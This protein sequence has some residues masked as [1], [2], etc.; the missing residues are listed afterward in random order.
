M[1]EIHHVLEEIAPDLARFPP[2]HGPERAGDIARSIGSN[3]KLLRDTDWTPTI[4]FA[5]G[6]RQ[7]ILTT[8][9]RG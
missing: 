7:Q 5:K 2:N 1:N 8:R 3:E 4:E 9:K 6:L